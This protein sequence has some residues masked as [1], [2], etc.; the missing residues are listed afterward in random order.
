MIG[1]RA[2]NT[3]RE[4]KSET[5]EESA[6]RQSPSARLFQRY[7]S[8]LA[9]T[10][11]KTREAWPMLTVYG[12]FEQVVS[13]VLTALVAVIVIATLAHLILRIAVLILFDFADPSQQEA[14]QA[15][16][17]MIMTVLM[18]LEFNHS[19]LSVPERQYGVVQVRTVLLIALLA[20]VR[21]FVLIDAAHAA[22]ETLLGLAASVL[23]LGGAYWLIREQGRRDVAEEN[24]PGPDGSPL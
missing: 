3:G 5:A 23:A 16:F 15:V 21:K 20:L 17:G 7:R 4:Q 6:A 8:R 10:L 24:T 11:L 2:M 1:R 22:P 14:F 9:G 18:A 13:L 12:R 19:I